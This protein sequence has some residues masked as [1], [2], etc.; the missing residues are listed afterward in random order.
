MKRV[1]ERFLLT[2][3]L[4]PGLLTALAGC[5]GGGAKMSTTGAAASDPPTPASLDAKQ[6]SLNQRAARIE[7]VAQAY[8]RYILVRDTMYYGPTGVRTLAEAFYDQSAAWL[9]GGAHIAAI[10]AK[11]SDLTDP[12]IRGTLEGLLA[13][14]AKSWAVLTALQDQMAARTAEAQLAAAKVGRFPK[15]YVPNYDALLGFFDDQVANLSAAIASTAAAY[16]AANRAAMQELLTDTER[17][18]DLAIKIGLA[19]SPELDAAVARA[20]DLMRAERVIEPRLEAVTA[21]YN[22]L[23]SFVVSSRV[24]EAEDAATALVAACDQADAEI[25]AQG[26]PDAF[27]Q[28]PLRV[29]ANM[30]AAGPE[31]LHDGLGIFSHADAVGDLFTIE[32]AQLA[33]KCR[34]AE[35]RKQVNCELFKTVF[36]VPPAAVRAMDDAGLRNV[37]ML[38]A[39]VEAGPLATGGTP[40]TLPVPAPGGTP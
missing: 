5:A 6:A 11:A 34:D 20:H 17:A 37:E 26:L 33:A 13:D 14:Q 39:R 18:V 2:V 23:S 31:Q 4:A 10:L 9:G 40:T 15:G 12:T 32:G 16:S 35:Q 7:E 25:R 1:L 29:I 36:A 24:F 8:G 27:V 22:R 38:I 3:M 19:S 30:K 28:G 21:L